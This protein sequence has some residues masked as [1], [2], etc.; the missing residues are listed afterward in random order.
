[1]PDVPGGQQGGSGGQ[2]GGHVQP[3]LPHHVKA[4]VILRTELVPPTMN[5]I[6]SSDRNLNM[7]TGELIKED[8][9]RVSHKP[10]QLYSHHAAPSF[11]QLNLMGAAA[12][13]L[14]MVG[15]E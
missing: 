12:S 9:V 8:A 15:R 3:P 7:E 6:H 1:M 11:P 4:L 14:P 5:N 13:L 2:G 10:P